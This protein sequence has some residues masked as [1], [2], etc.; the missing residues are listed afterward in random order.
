MELGPHNIS[1][2]VLCPGPVSTSLVATSAEIA[3]T[4]FAPS[5]ARK[6]SGFSHRQ[7]PAE[8]AGQVITAIKTNALNIMT[9]PECPTRAGLV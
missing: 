9:H 6:I 2:S 8:V 3:P 5:G 4:L 7:T 1:I